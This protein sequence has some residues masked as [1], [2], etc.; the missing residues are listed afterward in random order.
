VLEDHVR[1]V[2]SGKWSTNKMASGGTRPPALSRLRGEQPM[3]RSF[4]PFQPLAP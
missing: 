1:V 2:I 4:P 3:Q